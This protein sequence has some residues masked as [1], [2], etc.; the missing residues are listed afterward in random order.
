MTQRTFVF[1]R[2][3]LMLVSGVFSLVLVLF[4]EVRF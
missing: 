4:L 2:R 3:L 1:T